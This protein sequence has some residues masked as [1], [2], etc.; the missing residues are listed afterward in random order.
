MALGYPCMNQTLRDH[1]P[2]RRCNRG[3]QKRTWNDRGLPYASELTLQNFRDL[4]AIL[5]W[6][7][8][9]GISFYRITSDLVPWH[10]Q[11]ELP[12]LPDYE[13]IRAVAQ[14]CG[15]FIEANGMRVTFHP[16]HWC[17]LASESESTV[18][19]S[20]QDLENHGVWLDLLGLE[21][22]PYY[23]ITIHIGAHYG[24]KAATAERFRT[25]VERLSPAVRTRLTVENDDTESCWSVSE[26]VEAVGDPLDIPIVFDYHHHQFTSRG[27]SYRTAFTKAAATWPEDVRPI[28]HYSEPARLHEDPT[29]NPQAHSE[30]VSSIPDWLTANADVMVEAGGKERAVL[31]LSDSSRQQSAE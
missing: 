15:A 10:S 13:D 29:A 7:H 30:F 1:E 18:E 17:K 23:S 19:N 26:L 6:N 2:P 20:I 27:L 5:E 8:E 3:M 16:S 25:A 14:E 9:H 11:Y 4:R 24:D 12:E 31:S 21:R 22:S 28:A